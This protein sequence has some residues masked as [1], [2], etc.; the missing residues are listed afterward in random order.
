MGFSVPAD[1]WTMDLGDAEENIDECRTVHDIARQ[2]TSDSGVPMI[3]MPRRMWDLWSNRVVPICMVFTNP[4]SAQYE[5]SVQRVLAPHALSFFAVLR[6]W[7]DADKRRF[8]ETPINSY[9]W[10]MPLPAKATLERMLHLTSEKIQLAWLDVLCLR[11]R[12]ARKECSLRKEEA[13]P[14]R[15]REG[16]P[17]FRLLVAYMLMHIASCTTT[18]DSVCL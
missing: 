4:T 9:E 17:I 11:Q 12:D 15:L 13:Q 16:G 6:P 14:E 18:V 7:L 2:N 10:P 3:M 1:P 5:S 8:V